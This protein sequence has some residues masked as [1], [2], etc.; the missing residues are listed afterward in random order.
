[1]Y[2]CRIKTMLLRGA[3]YIIAVVDSDRAPSTDSV[4]LDEI[5][6]TC[7]QLRTIDEILQVPTHVYGV[8]GVDETTSSEITAYKKTPEMVC[9]EAKKLQVYITML[10]A[11][12]QSRNYADK[13]VVGTALETFNTLITFEK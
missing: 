1:M 13:G 9:Y 6:W 8:K 12:N 11:R 2:G 5:Y 3:K 4:K 7:L 10:Y